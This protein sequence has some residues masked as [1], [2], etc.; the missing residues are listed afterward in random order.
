MRVQVN[1]DKQV[2]VDAEFSQALK[3]EVKRALARFEDRLTTVEI[4]VSDVNS[5]K[6]GLRDKRCL[7]EAR[8]AGKKP[9]SANFAAATVEQAVRGAAGKMKRLLETSFGKSAHQT[10]RRSLR[11][12][13][14]TMRSART[15][16]KLERI[17]AT[18]S[19]VLAEADEESPHLRKQVETAAEALRKAQRAGREESATPSGPRTKRKRKTTA[20]QEPAVGGRSPKKKTVYRARR[21]AWPK[22]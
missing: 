4:F 19:E 5:A 18:L 10:S 7:V 17:E 13:K 22:R 11:E 6:P 12:G 2:K 21:K 16:Q 9:V 3:A 1:S 20:K 15:L 8:Q 14:G